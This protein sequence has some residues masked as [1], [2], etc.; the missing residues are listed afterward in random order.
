[1]RRELLSAFTE[2]LEE[3]LKVAFDMNAA[4]QVLRVAKKLTLPKAASR[5]AGRLADNIGAS[6]S[7]RLGMVSSPMAAMPPKSTNAFVGKIQSLAPEHARSALGEQLGSQIAATAPL[8]NLVAHPS[9]RHTGAILRGT[10]GPTLDRAI[11]AAGEGGAIG[12]VPRLTPEQMKMR[13][14]VFRGHEV[15]EL[16]AGRGTGQQLSSANF[17]HASPDVIFKEHNRVATLPQAMQPVGQYMRNMRQAGEG[18]AFFGPFKKQYGVGPR[19]SRHARR[20][21]TESLERRATDEM[22]QGLRSEYP[23]P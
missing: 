2:E 9:T 8:Q 17:M 21:M 11:Y 18:N 19:L 22:R 15:D 14:A 10:R 6:K 16:R 3:I 12:A 5:V 13:N 1:M 4:G 20:R 23:S 7:M